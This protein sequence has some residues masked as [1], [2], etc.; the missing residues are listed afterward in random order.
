MFLD[1]IH[2]CQ[3]F[4]FRTSWNSGS[5]GLNHYRH[6]QCDVDGINLMQ[7][8]LMQCFGQDF[9]R[10]TRSMTVTRKSEL[11][12]TMWP[13]FTKMMFNVPKIEFQLFQIKHTLD[14]FPLAGFN[15]F[16]NLKATINLTKVYGF[17]AFI[18]TYFKLLA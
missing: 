9:M 16:Q 3:I 10:K 4:H 8:K 18:H 5:S 12:I 6:G 14:R 15:G 11:C 7:C 13:W 17:F 1:I 2:V